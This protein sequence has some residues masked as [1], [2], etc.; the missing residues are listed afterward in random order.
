MASNL[1]ATLGKVVKGTAMYFNRDK[2]A[3]V[4]HYICHKAENP[5]VL[6]SVKLNKV[7]WYADV[8]HYMVDG[9]PITGETYVKRQLGPVP[10][11]MPSVMDQLVVTGRVARG[12]VDHYGFM[13]NEFISIAEPDLSGLTAEEVAR[14]DEAFDH[15]CLNHT[16]KSISD[17]THGVIWQLAAMGECMP[18]ST[19][20]ASSEGEIDETDLAWAIGQIESSAAQRA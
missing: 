20:F 18:Y 3:N 17:E 4:V 15:V 12:K 8:I 11:H 16:A 1:L 14:I 13:K 2:F 10:Q 7:L 6:G 9:A 19:V 5:A